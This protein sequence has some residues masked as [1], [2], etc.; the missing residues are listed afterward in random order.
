[1]T[2]TAVLKVSRMAQDT[3]LSGSLCLSMTY[4]KCF[5]F[6]FFLVL[7]FW[8]KKFITSCEVI[9][10]GI[11]KSESPI[12]IVVL[13][14]IILSHLQL[15]LLCFHIIKLKSR[16]CICRCYSSNAIDI[17]IE[18][19]DGAK[20]ETCQQYEDHGNVQAKHCLSIGRT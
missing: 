15:E 19:S 16:T 3:T 20:T 14:M 18:H 5:F 17:I 2:L 10:F 1:M 11:Y 6:F 7:N 8:V 4:L 9:N 13:I 12:V